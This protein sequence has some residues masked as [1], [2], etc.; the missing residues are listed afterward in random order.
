MSSAQPNDITTHFDHL[1][2]TGKWSRLYEL[3]DGYTYH[4]HLRRQRVLEL[5]PETLG[6]VLDVGCGTG[7]MVE[8]V[9]ARGGT[10]EGVELSASM[11]DE[12]QKKYAGYTGVTFVHGNVEA[13]R[14]PSDCYDQVIC[15][16]LIEYLNTADL[17]LLEISRVLRPS[18]TA[19]ITVPKRFHIDRLTIAL[20]APIRALFRALGIFSADRLPRLRLQPAELDLAAARAGLVRTSGSQYQFSLI[21]YPFT[22][23][24]PRLCMRF[25]V[26]FEK[27]HSTRALA[28]SFF[29]HGYVAKY[30]K[31]AVAAPPEPS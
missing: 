10:F 18:G 2:Q 22:R 17:A 4:F 27:W 7:V 21:P 19:V 6:R 13:L 9:V 29:A 25:N 28:K 1:A 14:L 5:L 30:Q 31:V 11:L 26:R 20:T 16:G 12:A 15:M 3:A 23:I 8:S 24:A